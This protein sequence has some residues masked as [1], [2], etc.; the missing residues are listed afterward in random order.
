MM[1]FFVADICGRIKKR[2][3]VLFEKI[4]NRAS[5][6]TGELKNHVLNNEQCRKA[7]SRISTLNIK[8]SLPVC[9]IA[10]MFLIS[11]LVWVVKAVSK[12]NAISAESRQS[13]S[14]LETNE[15]QVSR[16][17]IDR[18]DR[19]LMARVIEGEAADEPLVGKVAVGAVIINR[20]ESGEFPKDVKGVVYQ[21]LA[22]EAVA[23]GQYTRPV[24][25][26]SLQAA[27]LAIKGWDPT[28]GALYYWNPVT[29][30]SNWVWQKPIT[31]KIGK[32]VF[33]E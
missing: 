20:T 15:V 33:A 14:A 26:E 6:V 30:R 32:H 5:V 29:A 17:K 2:T 27:D 1:A 8:K 16:G 12:D 25:K 7:L 31:K 9:I 13:A 18:S 23:N 10:A 3:S 24:T 11:G 4:K 28:E 21:P 19:Y 22:F